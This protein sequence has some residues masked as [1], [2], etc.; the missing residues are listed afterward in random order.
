MHAS[1]TNPQFLKTEDIDEHS[2]ALATEM[3]QKEVLDKPQDMQAKILEGKLSAYFNDRVLLE[4]AF[5][6]NPD[7]TIRNLIESGVQKFGE[8]IELSRYVR[9]SITQ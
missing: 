4:Q 8:K 9:F 2:R 3:F 7:V 1:A 6:K 5:I